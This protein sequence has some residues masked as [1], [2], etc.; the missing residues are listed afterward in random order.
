MIIDR[1]KTK[2]E[3]LI[4]NYK[5]EP[6]KPRPYLG[7]SSIGENCDRRLWYQFRWFMPHQ[8]FSNRR[9]RL[10]K[11]G[12]NEEPIIHADLK[13]IG[14][15][16]QSTQAEASEAQGHIKAH[17]DGILTHVPDAPKTKHLNEIKTANDKSFQKL[18]R[19]SDSKANNQSAVELWNMTYYIQVVVYMFLFKL[20]RCLYIVVNKNDDERFYE[21]IKC[22]NNLAKYYLGKAVDII[23]S[24]I[25]PKRISEKTD[26]YYCKAFKC[27][28]YMIC[29]FKKTP[30]K[31][32]R[33]CK[34]SEPIPDGK[35]KCN[36]KKGKEISYKKQLKGCK[37]YQVLKAVQR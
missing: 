5:P 28:F 18:K 27:Q 20:K 29:H 15:I 21:R 30:A 31:N 26:F 4:E 14:I 7:V 13:K 1:S 12:H 37:K 16:I 9:L 6:E 10:F 36:K 22:D 17:N 2:T 32:C 35:W 3:E 25:A 11:R 24:Q 33:T 8:N 19:C 34:N 23:N